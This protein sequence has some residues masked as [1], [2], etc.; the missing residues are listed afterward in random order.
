MMAGPPRAIVAGHRL[1]PAPA[2][3]ALSALAI[4]W[5]I[6]TIV[7]FAPLGLL[8]AQV[9]LGSGSMRMAVG[10]VLIAAVSFVGF[11]VGVAHIRAGAALVKPSVR[12]SHQLTRTSLIHHGSVVAAFVVAGSEVAWLAFGGAAIGAAIALLFSA[13]RSNTA[14]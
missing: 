2:A 10:A 3:T 1:S 4:A 7:F 14:W 13:Y 5:G 9:A 12:Q 6:L 8:Y 11:A